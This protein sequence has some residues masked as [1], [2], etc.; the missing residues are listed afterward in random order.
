M[1]K[2]GTKNRL[3]SEADLNIV[4]KIFIDDVSSLLLDILKQ[5]HND[6]D[7]ELKERTSQVIDTYNKIK[8]TEEEK[9]KRRIKNTKKFTT[10]LDEFKS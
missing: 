1:R 8:H 10:F 9:I 2:P 5:Y 4:R 7:I 3:L 6:F